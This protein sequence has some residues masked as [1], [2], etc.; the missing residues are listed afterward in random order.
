MKEVKRTLQ[1]IEQG[2]P[3]ADN[4]LLALAHQALLPHRTLNHKSKSTLSFCFIV[5][6]LPVIEWNISHCSPEAL[7]EEPTSYVRK[8][9]FV[10]NQQKASNP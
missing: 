5:A 8:F 7:T 3:I 1:S 4:E 9:W 6:S 10:P 2:D